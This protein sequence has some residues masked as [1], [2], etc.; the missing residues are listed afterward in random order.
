MY[1]IQADA[2]NDNDN[3]SGNTEGGLESQ[4]WYWGNMDRE[5]ANRVLMDKEHGHF[6]VRDSTTSGEYTLVVRRREQVRN[7]RILRDEQGGY[8]VV[9]N[10][11]DFAEVADLILYL[12]NHPKF[13]HQHF[14]HIDLLYPLSK[15]EAVAEESTHELLTRLVL[16]NKDLILHNEQYINYVKQRKLTAQEVQQSK[17]RMTSFKVVLSLFEEQLALLNTELSAELMK[18]SA[19]GSTDEEPSSVGVIRETVR[20]RVETIGR[21]MEEEGRRGQ[22][23]T[24]RALRQ[25]EYVHQLKAMLAHVQKEVTFLRLNWMMQ[26]NRQEAERMLQQRVPGTFLVRPG[27]NGGHALSV[28][29]A[30]EESVEPRHCLIHKD[31]LSFRYGFHPDYCIFGSLEELVSKHQTISLRYYNS[32]LDVCL[33]YPANYR[34]IRTQGQLPQP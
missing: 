16:R 12:M 20:L 7:I 24:A 8:G 21:R 11:C 29:C 19:A 34:R 17:T 31:P 10:R 26:C 27:S 9:S 32:R 23:L 33:T 25:L 3:D 30:I 15:P 5:E 4:S 1:A 2:D 14:A 22:E 18:P 13:L 6:L 28:V